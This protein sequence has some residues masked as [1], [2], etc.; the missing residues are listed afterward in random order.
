MQPAS[1]ISSSIVLNLTKGNEGEES[2]QMD[3]VQGC[4]LRNPVLVNKYKK[5]SSKKVIVITSKDDPKNK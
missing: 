1:Q 3:T 2:K 4:R 5:E